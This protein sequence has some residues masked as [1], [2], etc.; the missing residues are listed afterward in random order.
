MELKKIIDYKNTIIENG[1]IYTDNSESNVSLKDVVNKV[2]NNI[3][4]YDTK[5]LILDKFLNESQA[6]LNDTNKVFI[7]LISDADL[8][9]LKNKGVNGGFFRSTDVNSNCAIIIVDKSYAYAAFDNDHVYEIDNT[10]IDDLFNYINYLIWSKGK[11][12]FCQ[13]R[14]SSV[15][16]A[17]LSVIKPVINTVIDAKH[18]A[19]TDEFECATN[20]L[21]KEM[22]TIKDSIVLKGCTKSAYVD[23]DD[24]FLNLFENAYYAAKDWKSLVSANSFTNKNL[25]ELYGKNLWIDGKKITIKNRCSIVED[26]NLPVDEY[27]SFAPDYEK[28]ASKNNDL[29]LSLE[30]IVNVNPIVVDNSYKLS[31]R[32]SKVNDAMSKL[33]D[34]INKIKNL[35]GEDKG[36]LKKIELILSERIIKNKIE[37]F[38]KFISSK[39]FGVEALNNEKNK[40]KSIVYDSNLEVPNELIGKL[41]EKNKTNYLAIKSEDKIDEASKWLKENNLEAVL[42]LG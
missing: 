29:T 17:R 28:I 1:F 21:V 39:D 6:L 2:I 33:N 5:N 35:S 42:I 37:L 3:I 25:N 20:L 8:A 14:V 10:R 31:G 30:V 7:G 32:Y 9:S 34:S 40:F 23:N 26:V 11:T 13:G 12:E 18:E 22:K 27:K 24:L 15:S 36:I 38:N 4:I 19:G 16:E 41:Y